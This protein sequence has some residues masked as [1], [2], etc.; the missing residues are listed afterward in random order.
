MVRTLR[1]HSEVRPELSRILAIAAAIAVHAFAFMLL[2]IPMAAPRLD[3]PPQAPE[4]P[5][6]I[7]PDEL[8]QPPRPPEIVPVR[9][10]TPQPQVQPRTVPQTN[11]PVVDQVIVDNGNIAADPVAESSS[12][13][14]DIGSAVSQP[15]AGVQLEY[16]FAPSPPYPGVAARRGQE[17][18]V[19]LKILVDTDGKPL[20]VQ[21]SKSSGHRILD[22][23]AQRFV[24][25]NWRFQPAMRNGQAVQ[26]YGLVPIDFSMQ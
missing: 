26:A 14:S 4:P 1:L 23:T 21:I 20:D 7:K 22:E 5:R 18:S 15:L 25:K 6:W 24:L 2:L 16:A 10:Q 9:P 12:P 8:I 11:P 19:L 3:A 13:T 17:G